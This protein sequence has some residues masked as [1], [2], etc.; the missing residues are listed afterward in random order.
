MH[1]TIL[2]VILLALGQDSNEAEK[3]FRAAEKKLAEAETVQITTTIAHKFIS[4]EAKLK[5]IEV[6]CTGIVLLAKGNKVRVD[7]THPRFPAGP[8]KPVLMSDGIQS[9]YVNHSVE[10]TPTDANAILAGGFSRAGVHGGFF[11][12]A[13]DRDDKT[14]TLDKLLPLSDFSLGK[15]EMIGGRQAQ[16][17]DYQF[18]FGF[19]SFRTE[20]LHAHVW[21]DSETHLPLKR[22]I[23]GP[24][25]PDPLH[26]TETYDIRLNSKI[27]DKMFVLPKKMT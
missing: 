2:P 8:I 18:R 19:S 17:I 7:L 22:V 4:A 24:F 9:L 13:K 25:V 20:K 5:D 26:V 6:K 16:K 12:M 11:S 3:L 23:S 15:K 21:L 14:D 27:N 10:K 1:L